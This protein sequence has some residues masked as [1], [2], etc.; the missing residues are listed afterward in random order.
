MEAASFGS[1][2]AVKHLLQCKADPTKAVVSS[3]EPL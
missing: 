3:Q 1:V 2:E